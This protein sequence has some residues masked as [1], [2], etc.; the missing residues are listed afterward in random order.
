MLKRIVFPLAFSLIG[1]FAITARSAENTDLWSLAR[2]NEG[3]FRFST[4]FTAQ[5]VRDRL[6]TEAGIGEAIEFCRANAI[7]RAFMEVY[8]DGY[9]ADEKTITHAR[10]RFR[11]AGFTVSG[12]VT[13]TGLGVA[14]TGYKPV[15]NYEAPETLRDCERVF[16]Y[17]ASL[18]DLIMID[19][20]L[21][22]DDE[23]EL[24]TRARGNR[25]WPE[26]RLDL[27]LRVSRDHII[28]PARA[29]NPSAEIII[30]FPQ[31]YDNFHNRG[32]DVDKQTALFDWIWVG[33]ETR[34]PDNE[35]W[36]RTA[37]YEA[38]FI[39]RWLTEQGGK[40]CGGGWFDT[41]GTSPETYVEQARQTVLGG[42]REAMLFHYG[43]IVKRA[44]VMAALRNEIPQLFD[45]AQTVAGARP[46]GA[47]APKIPNSAAGKD[48]YIFDFIGMLG[49]PLAPMPSLDPSYPA[50]V[51]AVSSWSDDFPAAFKAY[52]DAKKPVAITSNLA[53]LL[54][55]KGVEVPESV[56]VIG[57]PGDPR[58]LYNADPAALRKIGDGVGV[59]VSAPTRVSIYKYDNGALAIENFNNEAVEV[60]IELTQGAL[61]EEKSLKTIV[62]PS[63][64]SV[65]LIRGSDKQFTL[66][67]K[68]RSLIVLH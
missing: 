65:E 26:Y 4:L 57:V 8:R 54:K 14:S 29:V 50:A 18:F 67:M 56:I 1:L 49:V 47:L 12:C 64:G 3:V 62:F 11:E 35:R 33:T 23:S 9:T 52:L 27:M 5:D 39:M 17:A 43:E 7:T 30:K 66:K 16:A 48:Q 45:L 55:E 15:S 46:A 59:R 51:F 31:W 13:P 20:F 38:N 24:S 44:D 68:P 28:A 58:G 34:D 60:D 61:P 37:Q 36:G 6:G 53:A 42:A 32:Y 2:Q 63:S 21:F 10:D 19:D 41:Y 25:P 22:T 40:K